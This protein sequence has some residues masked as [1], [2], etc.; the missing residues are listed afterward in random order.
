[1]RSATAA[2]AGAKLRYTGDSANTA[3]A[4]A[5]SAI[6]LAS[7]VQSISLLKANNLSDLTNIAAA[8]L[9]IGL[10]NYPAVFTFDSCPSGL[11][12]GIPLTQNC[13]VGANFAGTTT[14]SGVNATADAVF[15]VSAFRG[16]AY[17]AIGT[18]TFVNAGAGIVLSPQPAFQLFAGDALVITLPGA[19]PTLAQVGITI[20]LTLS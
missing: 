8:R 6:N 2:L 7:Y 9:N 12:R 3:N 11:R 17:L 4:A 14:Y 15:T 10:A 16:G 5:A 18:I 1:M 19:D 13:T 20:P